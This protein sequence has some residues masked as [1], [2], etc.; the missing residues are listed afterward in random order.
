MVENRR[1][2]YT[3]NTQY[4]HKY[5]NTH[6]P[7]LFG[8]VLFLFRALCVCISEIHLNFHLFFAFSS[9][10]AFAI[11]ESMFMAF[12]WNIHKFSHTFLFFLFFFCVAA[13][14][15][16][17]EE[18]KKTPRRKTFSCCLARA[19]TVIRRVEPSVDTQREKRFAYVLFRIETRRV[20]TECNLVRTHFI[21]IASQRLF[22]CVCVVVVVRVIHHITRVQKLHER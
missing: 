12:E 11:A 17:E 3:R 21:V 14:K 5:I 1:K 2:R 10:C 6:T 4:K 19:R 8:R 7:P 9:M 16:E 20:F 18:G 15:N 22:E 13:R